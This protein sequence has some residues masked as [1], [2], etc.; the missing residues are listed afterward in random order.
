MYKKPAG[1]VKITPQMPK[2]AERKLFKNGFVIKNAH[3]G[4]IFYVKM[5]NGKP[6]LDQNGKEILAMISHHPKELGKGFV[7]N[8]IRKSKKTKEEWINL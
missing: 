8:I 7:K 1:K 3:G 2:E 6:V 4:D 5:N